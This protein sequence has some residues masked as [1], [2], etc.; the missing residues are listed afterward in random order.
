MELRDFWS[1]VFISGLPLYGII[2]VHILREI[3]WILV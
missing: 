2:V 3:G 1:G